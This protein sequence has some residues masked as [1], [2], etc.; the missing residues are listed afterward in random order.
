MRGGAEGGKGKG[1]EGNWNRL[2]NKCDLKVGGG[3]RSYWGKNVYMR[4]PLKG[5]TTIKTKI[6]LWGL[7]KKHPRKK[8]SRSR[9]QPTMK[10]MLK[11]K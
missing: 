3:K 5:Y 11:K 10:E 1:L 8:K 4:G 2:A 6:L 7:E 9:R